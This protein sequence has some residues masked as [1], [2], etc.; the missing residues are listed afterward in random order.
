MP[1]VYTTNQELIDHHLENASNVIRAQTEQFRKI[2]GTHTAK[3]TE[4]TRQFVGDYTS[5][6]QQMF[7]GRQA[8][9]EPPTQSVKES[10]FPA[11]PKEDIKAA[12]EPAAAASEPAVKQEEPLLSI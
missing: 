11:A 9:A 3:A 8:S 12:E 10:D 4:V 5:K 7:R 1:L 2:A 6:A